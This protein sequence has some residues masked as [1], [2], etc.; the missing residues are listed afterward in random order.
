MV[1]KKYTYIADIAEEWVGAMQ[2]TQGNIP[3][4]IDCRDNLVWNT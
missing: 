2:I 1:D 3:V 4:G